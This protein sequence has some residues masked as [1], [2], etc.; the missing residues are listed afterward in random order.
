MILGRHFSAKAIYERRLRE[1]RNLFSRLNPRWTATLAALCL[2]MLIF[3]KLGAPKI[4]HA[5]HYWQGFLAFVFAFGLVAL[6]Q[7]KRLAPE[8]LLLGVMLVF[9]DLVVAFTS[10]GATLVSCAKLVI[11]AFLAFESSRLDALPEPE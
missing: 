8:I 2:I 11:A 6:H 3:R 7:G 9:A 4:I 5:S 10:N 1:R